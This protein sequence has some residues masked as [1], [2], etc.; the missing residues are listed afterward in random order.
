MNPSSCSVSSRAQPRS[1]YHNMWTDPTAVPPMHGYSRN[2]TEGSSSGTRTASGKAK[3]LLIS[4]SSR[5]LSK[6]L[7]K[8]MQM[9][10]AVQR[11]SLF[12]FTSWCR[13]HICLMSLPSIPYRSRAALW[14]M[15][16]PKGLWWAWHHQY[17][18]C[19]HW[20]GRLNLR[21]SLV[22]CTTHALL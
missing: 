11:A 4:W 7:V 5:D 3:H 20:Q 22:M 1:P 13:W 10:I 6:K 17:G 21:L 18:A 15:K 12:Y 14:G 19:L 9:F 2:S 16:F 8:N